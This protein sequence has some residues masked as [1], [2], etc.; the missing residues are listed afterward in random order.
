VSQIEGEL[1][2][3]LYHPEATP[4]VT[5]R[6]AEQAA[7]EFLMR[8]AELLHAYGTPAYRLERVLVKLSNSLKVEA[9]FLS[10]PTAVIASLGTGHHK[11]V[12]LMRSDSGEVDLGKLVEF[13]E[14]MDWVRDE[15]LTPQEGLA[16]LN[17]IAAA[18]SRYPMWL[19]A[20]SFS[21]AS[22]AAAVFFGGGIA[23]VLAT[24]G[25]SLLTF[26]MAV[27]LS[28]GMDSIGIFE[29]LAAFTTA[30]L[31]AFSAHLWGLDARIVTLAG[32]VVLLPGL[33]LTL[34][35]LE[36]AMRHLVSGMSRLAGAGA[37]FLT[38]RRFD[39]RVQPGLYG[40]VFA[41][42]R[43]A[44]A[45]CVGLLGGRVARAV[46]VWDR[47]QSAQAR[48]RDHLCCECARL[49]RGARGRDVV[50]FGSR[51]VPGCAGGRAGVEHV[52]TLGRPASP[53][54]ADAG[55]FYVGAGVA[56]LP[57]SDLVPRDRLD[58]GD[59]VGLSNRARRRVV[60]GRVALVELAVAAAARVV[61]ALRYCP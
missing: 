26:L 10:T 59:G 14:T 52:R 18:P 13:D 40:R 9:S 1:E 42:G 55:H 45:G 25:L 8:V 21:G 2:P 23:E 3:G 41:D 48:A 12:R 31:A 57:Q 6:A 24:A 34:G 44:S 33:T 29:P 20:L 43:R 32:L 4:A 11:V 16:R 38:R 61:S 7:E 58:R 19:S 15:R 36:L 30:L 22:S 37:V 39:L 51:S 60:G 46:C 56:G 28:K 50:G 47:A 54:A 49:C 35:F 53:G 17:V 5:A 27:R